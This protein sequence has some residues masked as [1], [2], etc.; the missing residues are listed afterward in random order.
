MHSALSADTVPRPRLA[1][2][3]VS[4]RILPFSTHMFRI[5]ARGNYK[6]RRCTGRDKKYT[7]NSFVPSLARGRLGSG[8]ILLILID[9]RSWML[10]KKYSFLYLT[11]TI[12]YLKSNL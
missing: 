10:D 9:V 2:V 7:P 11:S 1:Q 6:V 5:R 8:L 12:Q 3:S 4:L